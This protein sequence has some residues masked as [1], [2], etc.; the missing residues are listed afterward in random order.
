[1]GALQIWRAARDDFGAA[2]AAY[3]RGLD[4]GGSRPLPELFETAGARLSMDESTFR[5]IVSAVTERVS[6]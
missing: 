1:M 2:V 4:L 3:R 6:A 5:E